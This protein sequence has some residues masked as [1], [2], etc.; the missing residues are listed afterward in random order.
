[1]VGAVF[2][3][4]EGSTLH[5]DNFVLS[6]RV[7][8]RGIEHACLASVLRHARATGAAT[9][10]GSYRPTAKN[11]TVKDFYPRYGFVPVTQDGTTATFRHDL[12]DIVAPP[13]HVHLTECL[14]ENPP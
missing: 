2:A 3:R 4:R 11:G 7:F 12:V 1:L 14:E 5:L 6:C 10:L 13:E 9:A 8:S